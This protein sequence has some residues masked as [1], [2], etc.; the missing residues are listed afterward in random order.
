M[1]Y[2]YSLLH[3]NLSR[4]ES[5]SIKWSII[6]YSCCHILSFKRIQNMVTRGSFLEFQQSA[7]EMKVYGR[8]F[9]T[10]IYIILTLFHHVTFGKI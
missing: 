1:T 7:P 2:F 5:V 6:L 9:E 4:L 10:D 8:H 3:Q